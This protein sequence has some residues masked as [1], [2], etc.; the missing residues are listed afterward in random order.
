MLNPEKD[1]LAAVAYF[2]LFDYPLTQTEIYLFLGNRYPYKQYHKALH[3]LVS[4]GM[5]YQLEGFYSLQ[6]NDYLPERR[7]KGNFLACRMLQTAERVA[8]FLYRFPFVRGVAVSGSLS[9]KYADEHSDIDLFIITEKNRLW[10]ARTILHL[11]KKFS[12]LFRREHLFCMNYFVDLQ[13]PEIS[14]KNIYT[15]IEIATL[16]PLKGID[17]FREFYDRNI[18]VNTYL[19]NH[20]MKV[21]YVSEG[22]NIL[23]KKICEV[24]M[25]NFAGNLLD[26]LLMRITATRWRKKEI[27]QQ[28]NKRG[29]VMG[30]N[31]SKH[32]A[33]PNPLHFQN[34]L[35]I[36]YQQKLMRVLHKYNHV[37]KPV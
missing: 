4:S 32:C 7:R 10:L 6:E 9:K 37:L 5:V 3:Q 11:M 8:A 35:V 29:I 13:K 26:S 30:M 21:T 25:N 14:E 36:S 28:K 19:P 20:S 1:I 2:D 12:F 17:A 33:K 18:W 31:V 27:N 34:N 22:N 15:A 23:L 16:I 24:L